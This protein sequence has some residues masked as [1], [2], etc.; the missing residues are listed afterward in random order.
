MNTLNV[1]LIIIIILLSLVIAYFYI[2][3]NL[4]E[5]KIKMELAEKEIQKNVNDKY[6]KMKEMQKIINKTLK[7]KEYL[8]AFSE[9][10]DSELSI[11]DLSIKLDE[12]LEIMNALKDDH[13]SLNTDE[14]NNKLQ[15]INMIDERIIANKKYY[16]KTNN[17]L[18]KDLKGIKKIVAKILHISSKSSYEI[19]EPVE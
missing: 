14:F 15:E 19:K 16:N 13:K 3:N 12:S 6:T 1:I 9:I 8:K 5:Y 7:K 4:T 2:A 17:L 11:N 10:D 18:L